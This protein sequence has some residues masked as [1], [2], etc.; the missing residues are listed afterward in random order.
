MLVE[1]LLP[2]EP[3]EDVVPEPELLELLPGR[4]LE[5]PL[6]PEL[7]E[8]DEPVLPPLSLGGGT[9]P[10]PVVFVPPLLL[11]DVLPEL[12]DELLAPL[13]DEVLLVVVPLDWPP[14]V[15]MVPP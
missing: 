11:D 3:P 5:P 9:Q 4:P 2:D 13:E 7:D 14:S 8:V 10:S 1:G 12:D 6:A 15:S